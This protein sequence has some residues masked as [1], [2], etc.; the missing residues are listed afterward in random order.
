MR[1]QTLA[2]QPQSLI[3]T[4]FIPVAFDERF[5]SRSALFADMLHKKSTGRV[6]SIV[7]NAGSGKST[8]MAEYHHLLIGQG[9]KTCW[10]NLDSDDDNPA[11][12]AAYL[13]CALHT[14]EPELA[15]NTLALI[16]GNQVR[17][18]DD[19]FEQLIER[20]SGCST[21]LA[22]FLDDFQHISNA[23]LLG[24]VNRLASHLPPCVRL[25]IASRSRLPLDLG[26]LRVHSL[27]VE[28]EQEALNFDRHNAAQVLTQV[29]G[30]ELNPGDLAALVELTEGWA[31][32]IQLAAL[33]LQRYNGPARTLIDSFS[34]KDRSLTSYLMESVLTH[35]PNEVRD[36]LLVTSPLRRMS[37]PLCEAVT[38]QSDR[39]D[40]LADLETRHVFLIPLDRQGYWF[41]YH[42]LFAEF[43]QQEFRRESPDA[44]Q[45][46]CEKAAKWCDSHG[47]TTE[48]IQYY[49]DCEQFET[50]SKLIADH[51][52]GVAQRS[53]DHY[54][55]LDWMRRLPLSHQESHPEILL[56]HAWSLAFSQNSYQAIELANRVLAKL[57]TDSAQ[58]WLLSEEARAHLRLVAQVTQAVAE[59]TADH[60]DTC[61]ARAMELRAKLP[62]HEKFLIAA[63]ENC[64]SYCYFAKREYGKCAD[65]AAEAYIFGHRSGA[66]FATA[67]ADF[68]HG[69]ANLELGK[70]KSA[71]EHCRRMSESAL[72]GGVTQSYVVGL[73]S[74]LDAEIA[75]Q[76]C[77]HE[78]VE[79]RVEAGRFFA[80]VFGPVEPLLLSIRHQARLLAYSGRFSDAKQV[81][82]NGQ[83][84]AL[85]LELPRLFVTLAIEEAVM[86]LNAGDVESALDAAHRTRLRDDK[87]N[88]RELERTGGLGDAMQLF[89]ARLLIATGS[90]SE[91][92]KMLS[93]LEHP[94]NG[95]RSVGARLTASAVKAVA[96]WCCE[97]RTDAAREFDQVL[98]LAARESHVYPLFCV[99]KALVP[100]LQLLRERRADRPVL[101]GIDSKSILERR[102]L[103]LLSGETAPVEPV[104]RVAIEDSGAPEPLTQRETE[105]LRL[106]EAGLSNKQLS[107]QLLISEATAKWHL[108][109][110]YS[111]MGVRSRTAATAR[112]RALKLL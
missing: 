32:A 56:S 108:H 40:M 27:L 7:A 28:I 16:R 105:L 64:L 110:I 15:P 13:V 45:S 71:R 46:V 99:G 102:L 66:D 26:R 51:A 83:D 3:A 35:Q 29:H 109:N 63:I 52:L 21:E 74:L 77:E 85:R 67:W 25:V 79:P 23:S 12:F 60:L 9:V 49:L 81:L 59:A 19:L 86:L 90:A 87:S 44:Y 39:G 97:R 112:A 6:L 5:V 82:M 41:R 57:R 50:A 68:L 80:K 4:K 37:K 1:N 22:L 43:L 36:F 104:L 42:H 47:H 91:A 75:M 72:R 14:A 96:L 98:A 8:V 18:F 53:G 30:L 55:V 111:K 20:I 54:T 48:A 33:A 34:G 38:G 11:A 17:D 65:A 95:A 84:L 92:L 101:D 58:A 107:T 70:I 31:T 89:E 10:L 73:A 93:L 62:E 69:L 2:S 24:F 106:V 100:I 61:L 76:T 103:R 88:L 94:R 78:Q